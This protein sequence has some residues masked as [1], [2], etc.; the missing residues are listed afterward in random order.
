M[1]RHNVHSLKKVARLSTNDRAAVLHVLNE[2]VGK[3]IVKEGVTRSVK[4]ISK[5][6]SDGAS[7]TSS[8]NNNWKNWV[9]LR[10]NEDV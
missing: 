8:V 3:H 2:R 6:V 4:V 7:S 1:L 10:G 9:V 5:S